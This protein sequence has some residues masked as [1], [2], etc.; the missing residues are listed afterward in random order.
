MKKIITLIM[1]GSI[2]MTS[3]EKQPDVAVVSTRYGDMVL[4]F[5]PE[6]AEKHVDS[7]LTHA[8]NGYFN[9][10]TFHRVIPD[11]VIQGGDPNSKTD[12]RSTHGMGGHA[13]NFYGIG[14]ED[15]SNTWMLPAEFNS[16]PH[17][18]GTI[19]MARSQSPNSAGSQF[20]VCAG[21]TPQLDNQYTVFGQV[22]EGLD[23]IQKIVNSP[24]DRRDNP[25]DKVEMTVSVMPRNEALDN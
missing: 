11:F 4:E 10:T 18:T 20:F 21:P 5:Y 16:R 3:C 2:I 12:D 7:F 19:S 6:V 24:R 25:K 15:D 1:I 14:Q 9:G 13:A 17:L 8:R 23:V 22:V